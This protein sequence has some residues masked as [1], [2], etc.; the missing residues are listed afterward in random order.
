MKSL[1]KK[2]LIDIFGTSSSCIVWYKNKKKPV[3]YQ[4]MSEIS[5][6]NWKRIIKI[7]ILFQQVKWY[8]VN[9]VS[10]DIEVG[11]REGTCYL[12]KEQQCH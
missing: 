11:E 8:Y 10:G 6:S 2:E 1:T 5:D 12:I 7:K 3:E 4:Q 9:S